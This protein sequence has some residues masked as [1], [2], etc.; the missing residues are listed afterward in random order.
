[1]DGSGTATGTRAPA[2]ER[3]AFVGVAGRHE[4]FLGRDLVIVLSIGDGRIEALADGL[5]DAALREG[6]DLAGPTVGLAADQVQD[7]TG[8]RG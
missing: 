3:R 8:L 4:E 6:D 7:L 1:M 5:G 2:L